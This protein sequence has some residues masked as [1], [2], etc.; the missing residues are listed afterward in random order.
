MAKR[1]CRT[2]DWIHSA[3]V[4]RSRGRVQSR[5]PKADP[6]VVLR[7]LRKLQN[8]SVAREALPN[9]EEGGRAGKN[10]PDAAGRW[11][12]QPVWT[13]RRIIRAGT[14]F[15]EGQVIQWIDGFCFGPFVPYTLSFHVLV[16]LS[17]IIP[18]ILIDDVPSCEM[19]FR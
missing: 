3:R 10:C 7:V 16:V 12:S 13:T 4:S 11:A 19:N 17:G 18:T 14:L 2:A 5:A 6:Q 1:R 9:S 15:V 8:A